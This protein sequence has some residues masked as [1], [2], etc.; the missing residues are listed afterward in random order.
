[1]AKLARLG[2]HTG[3]AQKKLLNR[4]PSAA[5]RSRFGVINSWQPR[6]FAAHGP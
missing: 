3:E 4:I 6:Q 5:K 1:V 2:E